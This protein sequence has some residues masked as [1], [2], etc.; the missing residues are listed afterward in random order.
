MGGVGSG[1]RIIVILN[2]HQMVRRLLVLQALV[3][4]LTYLIPEEESQFITYML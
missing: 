2:G 1:K 4:L 3:D